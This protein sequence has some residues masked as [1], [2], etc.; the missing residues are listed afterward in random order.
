MWI[1]PQRTYNQTMY[2]TEENEKPRDPKS[3][4]AAKFYMRQQTEQLK[5]SGNLAEQTKNVWN[6][7]MVGKG[8]VQDMGIRQ[9]TCKPYAVIGDKTIQKLASVLVSVNAKD[10]VPLTVDR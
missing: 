4:R 5:K 10:P 8:Y 3:I 7:L 2:T 9:D 1:A 6:N